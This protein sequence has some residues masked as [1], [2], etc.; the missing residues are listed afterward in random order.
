MLLKE[1]MPRS[2]LEVKKTQVNVAKFPVFDI[3]TH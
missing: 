1:Y 2:F 3:H